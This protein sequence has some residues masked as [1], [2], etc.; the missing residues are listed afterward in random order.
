[1]TKCPECITEIDHLR[2]HQK[3]TWKLSPDH[4]YQLLEMS[5]EWV[6][7]VCGKVLFSGLWEEEA[8]AYKWLE[9]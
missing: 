1:M 7:P 4:S 9:Q 5:M 6:C 2:C 8:E 3:A